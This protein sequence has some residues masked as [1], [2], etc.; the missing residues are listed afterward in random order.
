MLIRDQSS[1]FIMDGERKRENTT[2]KKILI[3]FWFITDGIDCAVSSQRAQQIEKHIFAL[4]Q[5][6]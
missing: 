6:K 4:I 3:Y 5:L 1:P 2:L